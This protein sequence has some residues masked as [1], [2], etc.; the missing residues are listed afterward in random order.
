M[1]PF[2]APPPAFDPSLLA[3]LADSLF[4]LTASVE[5]LPGERDQNALLTSRTGERYVLK[6]ANSAEERAKLELQTAVLL[7][8]ARRDPALGTPKV[9]HTRGGEALAEARGPDGATHCVRLLSFVP[10]RLLADCDR[11]P[12]LLRDLGAFMGRLDRALQD[13]M[14]GAA[15]RAN[16]LW[17]LDSALACR[18]AAGEI[19]DPED[20]DLV[21]RVFARH[22]R[23][24]APRLAGLR[25]AV[26]HQDAN[27]YNILVDPQE[28]TR[29]AGLIDFGDM[30]WGRQVNEL[31][32]TLAYVLLEADDPLAAAAPVIAGYHAELP[33]LDG[34]LAVLFDL[35]ALRLAMSVS[36]SSKRSKAHP[37]NDYLLVSQAPALALLRKLARINP[38]FAHFSFRAACGLPPVSGGDAVAA[39][40]AENRGGFASLLGRDLRAL[41]KAYLSMA[42]GAPGVEHTLD[43]SAYQRFID[44][45]LAERDAEVAIGGYC[46]E[47][48][49]YLGDNFAPEFGG[50]RRTVHLG[51]DIFG[52]E[53]TAVHAPLDAVVVSAEENTA[54]LDYGP[55]IILEHRCGESGLK[56]WTLYGHLSRESLAGLA[57]GT[58]IAK[59]ERFA[60]FGGPEVNGGWAPHLHFQVMTDLMGLSG[61]FPGVGEKSR[62][63]VWRAVCLDPNLILGL[64][65]EALAPPA[66]RPTAELSAARA[67]TL[68]P[69]LSLSYRRPLKILRGEG[70]HLIDQQGRAYLDCVNNICHVGHCHPRVVA[71]LADQAGRL[72]TNTRYLHDNIVDYAERLTATLPEPLEVCFFVCSGSEANELALRLARTHTG[73]EGAIV[74][75]H[76]YHGNTSG[77]VAHS[78][79]K[80]EGPGGRGLDPRARKVPLPDPYR[81]PISAPDASEGQAQAEALA[82]TIEELTRA[83]LL[84]ALL[85]RRIAARR[86]RPGGP[87]RGLSGGRLR[88][89]APG[90]RALHRR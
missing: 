64:S 43:P 78:P 76:A 61:D 27:D 82:P 3:S 23:V 7:H 13:F 90:R 10:G 38:D 44:G 71:A 25:C 47:R 46:E 68:G 21:E 9:C 18:D 1:S 35:I 75:D 50:E 5:A 6:V 11:P 56:V 12:A 26:I 62:L 48:A 85:H 52:P 57:P 67:A 73:R 49:V 2:D 15:D 55:T 20:R 51:I 54:Q 84:P 89:G 66:G 42:A 41:G 22:E 58:T 30:L 17:N 70:V 53:A 72:N 60:S 63:A 40:L 39:W 29:I 28:P 87:A 19:A 65:P 34:E 31:A 45:Y 74:V 32:V 83:G 16:F 80:C 79:Y 88:R 59:G 37:E 69:S 86:G 33:L 36:I 81:N 4:G 8:L 77:L 24:V 14:H